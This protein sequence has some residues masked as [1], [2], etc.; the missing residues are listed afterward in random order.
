MQII[1]GKTPKARRCLLYGVGGIG[2]STWAAAAPN[3]IFLNFEDGLDDIDC[4][5][6]PWLTSYEATLDAIGFLLREQTPYQTV[7][8]DSADWL[9][10]LIFLKVAKDAGKKSIEEIGYGKGYGIAADML[11]YI[12]EGLDTLRRKGMNVIFLAHEKVVKFSQPGGES[13]DRYTPA[14]H[15]ETAAVLTEWCDEVLFAHYETFTKKED[16][17]FNKTRSFAV[18]GST[19]VVR[20]VE[21][22]SAIAKNRLGMPETIA[23]DWSAYQAFWSKPAETGSNINGVVVNGSSK[24][25]ESVNA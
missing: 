6:S 3:P 10:S 13:F 11:S 17:G 22:A 25:K 2:K 5:K 7:V 12:C 18:G 24:K 23:L 9:E 21:N 20:C 1:T 8:V 14:M 4:S 16:L 15:R 19:R